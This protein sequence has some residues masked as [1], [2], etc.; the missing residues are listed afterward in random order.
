[1]WNNTGVIFLEIMASLMV[2]FILGVSSLTILQCETNQTSEAL[3]EW[4]AYWALQKTAERWKAGELVNGFEDIPAGFEM[5]FHETPISPRV[6]EGEFIIRW[7]AM[8]VE[9]ERSGYA[10][11]MAIQSSSF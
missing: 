6:Q 9:K 4:Q 5:E 3:L 10:Y 2:F 11:R 7:K 8:G 1:V